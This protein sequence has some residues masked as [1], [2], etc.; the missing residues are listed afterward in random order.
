MKNLLITDTDERMIMHEVP[1]A[2]TDSMDDWMAQSVCDVIDN[3]G[4]TPILVAN[5]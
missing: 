1:R 5:L 3:A 4:P 2:K